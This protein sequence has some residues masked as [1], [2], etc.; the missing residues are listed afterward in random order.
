MIFVFSGSLNSQFLFAG[1]SQ[2]TA[3]WSI[4]NCRFIR[5]WRRPPGYVTS[6]S[7]GIEAVRATSS[8]YTFFHRG[9]T[10]ERVDLKD[11][12]IF[13]ASEI[14]ASINWRSSSYVQKPRSP[15]QAFIPFA[16]IFA[17]RSPSHRLRASLELISDL[18]RAKVDPQRVIT[19][20]SIDRFSP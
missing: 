18:I 7:S 3:W 17:D 2:N 15:I 4:V 13:C 12:L 6:L 1:S 10:C 5:Y 9:M 16:F 20:K 11:S 19:D 8:A 14:G